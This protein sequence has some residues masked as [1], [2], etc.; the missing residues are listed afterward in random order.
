MKRYYITDRRALGGVTPLLHT[1]ARRLDDGVELIQIR[2]K[3]LPVRELTALTRRVVAMAR[4]YRTRILVN[5]RADVALA[6]GADGVH[7]PGDSIPPVRLREI[8]PP[9]FLIGVSCHEPSEVRR[10]EAEAADF[11]VFSPIFP[12]ISKPVY[13]QPKGLR[14]LAEVCRSVALPVYALGGVTRKNAPRCL[15]AGAAGVAGISYFQSSDQ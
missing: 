9:D 4:G 6:C 15:D 11:V 10:A 2:E 7:L 1:I 13:G 8:A 3:D 12:T 14:A 5:D